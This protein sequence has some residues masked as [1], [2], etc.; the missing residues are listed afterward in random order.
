MYMVHEQ[1]L[2]P[3]TVIKES[4][5]RLTSRSVVDIDVVTR[6][7]A[8]PLGQ[9]CLKRTISCHD[10]MWRLVLLSVVYLPYI[11]GQSA[12]VGVDPYG[13]TGEVEEGPSTRWPL[14]TRWFLG[15][16]EREGLPQLARRR[17]H[18][19]LEN[20]IKYN[21]QNKKAP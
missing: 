7:D 10:V 3:G 18:L 17:A 15:A 12:F 4:Y 5:Q 8:A 11:A 9:A 21:E 19:R 14:V 6:S 16:Q 13:D 2:I 1:Y 20:K